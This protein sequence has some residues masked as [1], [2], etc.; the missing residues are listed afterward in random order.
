[1]QLLSDT[2]LSHIS[3]VVKEPLAHSVH[4]LSTH[5]LNTRAAGDWYEKEIEAATNCAASDNTRFILFPP[6]NFTR[7]IAVVDSDVVATRWVRI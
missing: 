2:F 3:K 6:A 7:S 4:A 5:E 1:M